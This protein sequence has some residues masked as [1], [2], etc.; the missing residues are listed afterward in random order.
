MT[1]SSAKTFYDSASYSLIWLRLAESRNKSP[2]S[3]WLCIEPLCAPLCALIICVCGT[4]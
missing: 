3:K 2:L 4:H 1:D